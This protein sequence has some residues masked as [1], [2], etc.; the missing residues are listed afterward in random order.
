MDWLG[1]P[2]LEDTDD[3]VK[4]E[5]EKDMIEDTKSTKS[6]FL[7]HRLND[8][9]RKKVLEKLEETYGKSFC[10]DLGMKTRKYA[11]ESDKLRAVFELKC[12]RPFEVV[13]DKVVEYAVE[14]G[15]EW[16]SVG[17]KVNEAEPLFPTR[18]SAEKH[19]KS[20]TSL[21]PMLEAFVSHEVSKANLVGKRIF[22]VNSWNFS[23]GC[24]ELNNEFPA[25][26]SF[27]H[28]ADRAK[29]NFRFTVNLFL[30]REVWDFLKY[31]RIEDLDYTKDNK[32]MITKEACLE[33]EKCISPTSDFAKSQFQ[34]V[35]DLLKPDVDEEFIDWCKENL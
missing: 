17:G 27:E 26:L 10:K 8:D 18:E 11:V 20:F 30:Q 35:R 21:L 31:P 1:D 32:F 9:Q 4:Q 33:F 3:V 19:I 29:H 28:A 23:K 5:R 24:Y 13:A 15:E 2:K 25:Y 12:L 16:W 14:D 6:A 22:K 34:W 7:W